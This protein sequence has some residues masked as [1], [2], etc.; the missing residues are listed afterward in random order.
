MIHEPRPPQNRDYS[1]DPSFEALK[2]KGFINGGSKLMRPGRS[3]S[4]RQVK[5]Q[6]VFTPVLVNTAS[7][8]VPGCNER[9]HYFFSFRGNWP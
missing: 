5:K 4:M 7:I 6:N 2:R 1:R 9:S 8:N 3:G